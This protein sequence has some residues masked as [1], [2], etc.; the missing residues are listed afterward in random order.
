[1]SLLDHAKTLT[2]EFDV[3]SCCVYS[4]VGLTLDSPNIETQ[5]VVTAEYWRL[6][7]SHTAE[8]VSWE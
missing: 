7:Q 8:T 5:T 3:Y 1:M 4:S 2:K 6:Y